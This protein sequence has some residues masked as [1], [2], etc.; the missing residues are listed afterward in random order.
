METN[1]SELVSGAQNQLKR[2]FE[3]S[4]QGI[5]IYLD[6]ENKVCNKKFAT[7]LGYSSPKEWESVLDNIPSVFVAD[8]DVEKVISAF[9]NA[10][11]NMVGTSTKV[12]WKKKNGGT[13]KTNMILVPII[14][15]DHAMALHFVEELK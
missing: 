11:K 6:D 3:S 14:Y 12:I 1:H 7:M 4:N 15:D 10:I 13:I 5:Y 2:I 9:Q 8:K